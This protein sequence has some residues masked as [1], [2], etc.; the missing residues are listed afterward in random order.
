MN[1]K[2]LV[3]GSS[4]FVGSHLCQTFDRE[5]INYLAPSSSELNIINLN[6]WGKFRNISHLVHLAGKVFVPDSWRSPHPFFETNIMGTLNALE[7]CYRQQVPMTYIS[8][9][10]YGNSSTLP[11]SEKN[12]QQPLNPYAASKS[13]GEDLCRYYYK[14][15]S[16]SVTILRLFNVYGAGQDNRFLI[17]HII[18]EASSEHDTITVK[19]LRPKRDF[20]YVND[21]CE[22][23]CMSLEHTKGYNLFNVGSGKSY[24]V[25]EVINIVQHV[26]GTFKKVVSVEEVR[27]EEVADVKA[28]ITAIRRAWGWR[29]QYSLEQGIREWITNEKI[30]SNQ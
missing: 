23:I 5:K 7:F 20:V 3:T 1:N 10:V 19:D 11:L 2:I 29:P 4:G 30:Y 22:A 25:G 15:F 17:R 27:K 21:V 16:I 12:E 9:Y 14:F 24:S 18:D 28:D 13:I 6:D 26:M 8:A